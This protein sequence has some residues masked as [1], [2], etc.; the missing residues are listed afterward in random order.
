MK[1]AREEKGGRCGMTENIMIIIII[2]I[3]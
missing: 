2:I 3:I 1:N